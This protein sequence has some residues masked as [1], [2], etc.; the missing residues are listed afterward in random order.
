[1]NKSKRGLKQLTLV[2][3]IVFLGTM[4]AALIVY[5]LLVTYVPH[6]KVVDEIPKQRK[7]NDLLLTFVCCM[8]WVVEFLFLQ[9]L[10]ERLGIAIFRDSE[11]VGSS[12]KSH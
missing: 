7:L 5:Y 9:W 11:Q 1:M 8:G 3:W 4:G 2:G 10:L 12:T 6:G